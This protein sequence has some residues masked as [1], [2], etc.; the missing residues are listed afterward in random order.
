[1]PGDSVRFEAGHR[2]S[3]GHTA[4]PRARPHG[5]ATA[6]AFG[7]EIGDSDGANGRGHGK[8]RGDLG[9]GDLTGIVRARRL[10][11]ATVH[12][13]RRN[14]FFAF[15]YNSLGVPIAAGLLYPFFRVLLSP[16]LAAA[17]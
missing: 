11:R 7:G 8:C 2:S 17:P 15:A 10:S 5:S 6:K 13:I 16:M 1:M 9:A 4:G 3:A 14:L 12:S